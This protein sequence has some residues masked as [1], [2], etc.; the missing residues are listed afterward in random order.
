MQVSQLLTR[1]RLKSEDYERLK[2]L[3]KREP[4]GVEL[5]LASALWNEH[6]SYRSSITYLRG[7]SFPSK[8]QVSAQQE[9]AGI[10]DLGQ[11]ERIT[12]K[13]ESHNHPS[14]ITPFQGAATGVGG[15]LRDIFAMNARPLL[16]ANYLCFGRTTQAE[17]RERVREVVRGIS[18]Y[19][20]CIGVPTLIGQTEFSESYDNNIL[21]NALALGFLGS[22]DKAM[23]SVA[24]GKGNWLV[25][26]GAP[27]GRDGILGAS[28]ASES[29]KNEDS[30]STVQIGDPFY[31]K[32]LIEACLESMKKN[33]ILACQDMGAA[34]LTCSSFE[35]AEKACIGLKLDLEKV[36][37]RD[38]SMTPEDILLSESQ[39]RMLFICKPEKFKELKNIFQKYQLP[40]EVV[41]EVTEGNQIELSY[42]KKHLTTINYKKW[43]APVDKLPLTEPEPAHRTLPREWD[44]KTLAPACLLEILKSPEGR[45]R[46]FIY[47]QYDKRVGTITLKASPYPVAVIELPESK[48]ELAVAMGC[49]EHVMSLD[50]REGSKDAIYSPALDLALRGFTPWAVTDCLNFGNPQNPAVMG[51][52]ALSTKSLAESCKSLDTPIISGNVSFY[53]ETQ[54]KSITPTPAIA[55][56][57]LKETSSPL[58]SQGFTEK[59]NLVYLIFQ[60]QFCFSG[61][62]SKL[63]ARKSSQAFGVLQDKLSSWFIFSVL[64]LVQRVHCSACKKVG[65]FGLLYSLA[66]MVLDGTNGFVS[67]DIELDLFQERLY[68]SVLVIPA[69]NKNLLEKEASNLGLNLKFLG[70]V[71]GQDLQVNGQVFSKKDM[72]QAYKTNWKDIS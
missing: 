14:F 33:L 1:Y 69:E 32:Q 11:G 57:G 26:A 66:N 37:L 49:R 36:P 48:R 24:K 72:E 17:S 38:S 5:A 10:V 45:S 28:M 54:G 6:C 4:V 35:M 47:R 59:G 62:S 34:G 16:L 29:L 30:E 19:G 61:L 63:K 55:M 67:E 3:L 23:T 12:F 53:N 15:I 60:H 44:K 64:K 43:L 56:I 50:V 70:K 7:F 8:K 22:K 41:G 31:G 65:K 42:N 68:E 27:T 9:Q 18:T 51:E 25:Y 2:K 20:N 71:Q 13:M 52:F 46:E 40:L 58:P 39:E 21:V